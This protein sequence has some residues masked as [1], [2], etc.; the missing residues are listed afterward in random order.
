MEWIVTLTGDETDLDELTKVWTRPDL[1]IEKED[2]SYI[3]K[4]THFALLISDREV[5]ERAHELLIPINAG[6]KLDLGGLN[7][8]KIAHA[9][10][11]NPD[12]SKMIACSAEFSVH[13][14]FF[15]SVQITKSD[16][17]TIIYNSADS[18]VTLFNLAQSDPTVQKICQYLNQDFN[19]WHT[20]Y[21]IYELIES[22]GLLPIQR[23]GVY[24]KKADLFRRTANNPSASGLNSRHA[25]DESP[26]EKPMS[27]SEGQEFIKRII[28]EWIETKRSTIK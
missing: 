15:A 1:T 10:Q 27:L 24:R 22:S 20:L 9:I 11:L 13:A 7:P 5:R 14:R 8:I 23:G 18:T 16:G 6:I 28:H 26:P 12:G 2:S 17:T 3:L 4:S 19:S 21:K 25:I